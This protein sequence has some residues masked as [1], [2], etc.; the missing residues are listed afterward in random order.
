[1]GLKTSL[2]AKQLLLCSVSIK[3]ECCYPRRPAHKD[4]QKMSLR[5]TPNPEK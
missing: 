3:I 1:M 2:N 5:I 4:L